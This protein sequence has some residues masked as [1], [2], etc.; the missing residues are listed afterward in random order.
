[1]A[2]IRNFLNSYCMDRIL[3][4]REILRYQK[5]Y[6]EADEIRD[7]L[8]KA[9]IIVSDNPDGSDWTIERG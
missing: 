1:M 2:S 6:K 4:Q 3:S 5:K 8:K 7:A 9:H